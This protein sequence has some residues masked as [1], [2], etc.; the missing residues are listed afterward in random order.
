MQVNLYSVKDGIADFY[1]APFTS[2]NETAAIRSVESMVRKGQGTI[3][4]YP[5]HF[6]VYEVGTWNDAKG[7]IE[8]HAPQLVCDCG[9]MRPEKGE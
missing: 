9:S 6:Q 5:E 3:G 1:G 8:G 2:P 7:I 4:E